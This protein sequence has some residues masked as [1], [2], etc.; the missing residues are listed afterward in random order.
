LISSSLPEA[1]EAC[2]D[3]AGHEFD[4]SRQHALLRAATYGLAF[5]RLTSSAYISSPFA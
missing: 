2:I 5:C 3:A 4:I 1:I